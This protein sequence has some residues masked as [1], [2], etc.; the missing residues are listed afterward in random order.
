MVP[1]FAVPLGVHVG[2]P[3]SVTPAGNGSDR[4]TELASD[5]PALLATMVYV[6]VPPGV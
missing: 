6:A 3:V 5:G 2:V 1:Q 4:T